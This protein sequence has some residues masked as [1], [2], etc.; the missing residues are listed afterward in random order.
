MYATHGRTRIVS[1]HFNPEVED[2]QIN[3]KALDPSVI[4][5]RQKS[6]TQTRDTGKP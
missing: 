5:A 1:C 6:K 2:K 4:C 3:Q